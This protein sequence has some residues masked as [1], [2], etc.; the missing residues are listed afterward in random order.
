[1]LD[2]LPNYIDHVTSES[3]NRDIEQHLNGCESCKIE[4][5]NMIKSINADELEHLKETEIV[6]D[7]LVKTRRMY[8]L[9]VKNAVRN[10]YVHSFFTS[11][12]EF[13]RPRINR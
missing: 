12:Y 2:L 4:C 9:K 7:G 8:M 13:L 5:L 10:W 1:M 6:K 3:T 11:F